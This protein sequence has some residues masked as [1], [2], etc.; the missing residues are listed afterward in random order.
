MIII[1]PEGW[2]KKIKR[3]KVVWYKFTEQFQEIEIML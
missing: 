3:L 2:E 1:C